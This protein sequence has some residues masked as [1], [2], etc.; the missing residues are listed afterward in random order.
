MTQVQHK[1][2]NVVHFNCMTRQD[3]FNSQTS[4]KVINIRYKPEDDVKTNMQCILAPNFEVES[5]GEEEEL[6]QS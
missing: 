5:Q 6:R 3:T 2:V 4:Q 1:P